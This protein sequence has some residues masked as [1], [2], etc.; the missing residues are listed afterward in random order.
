MFR[1]LSMQFRACTGVLGGGSESVCMCVCKGMGKTGV[2]KAGCLS[3][4]RTGRRSL[5]AQTGWE[6]GTSAQPPGSCQ[7]HSAWWHRCCLPHFAGI[8]S[9]C[10][11][12][13]AGTAVPH[14]P[15]GCWVVQVHRGPPFTP[16]LTPCW[17]PGTPGRTAR[18]T[19]V[20]VPT[21]CTVPVSLACVGF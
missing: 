20:P 18:Q 15:A 4:R 13:Q 19:L 6:V 17:A 3:H 11:G 7:P 14:S 1:V 2:V 9:N 5:Q 21:P 8:T 16:N 12:P 10:P